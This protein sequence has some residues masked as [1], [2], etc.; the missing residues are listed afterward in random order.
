MESV[1]F[2]KTKRKKKYQKPKHFQKQM[3]SL[4]PNRLSLSRTVRRK[5]PASTSAINL[6]SNFREK[7]RRG[8][9]ERQKKKK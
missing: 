4:S 1:L 5:F 8:Q 3:F 9:L 2:S 7:P 6:K